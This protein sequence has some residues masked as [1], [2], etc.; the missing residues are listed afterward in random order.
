[1]ARPKTVRAPTTA[2]LPN[3]LRIPSSTPSLT[4]SL[5]KLSRQALL[6]LAFTWLDDRN[7]ASSPPYLQTNDD[8]P[9]DDDALPYPAGKTIEEVRQV[10][11]D[12]QDRK[13]AKR[14]LIERILEGD[15]R[16][17]ITL[18][19]LAMADL[20]YMD[21]HPASLRWT[22]LELSRID[23]KRKNSK[24]LPPADW[25]GSVPRMQAATFVQSLQREISP[26]V[27]AHYHL[28]HSATLPLTFLR[29]FVVDS[30]YQSPRQA[31]EIFTDSSRVIYVAFPDSCPYVYTSIA[32]STGSKSAPSASSVAT[33]TRTLQRL[34]RDS[35]PKALSRPQE[36]FSL[37]ATSLAAKNLPTLL[38]L[39]GSGR[40]TASNGAFSIFADA[41]TEGSP[42]DPRPSNTVSPEEHIRAS[43]SSPTE[44]KENTNGPAT[45]RRSSGIDTAP[46]SPDS[47]KRCL[48]IHSRF[49]TLGSSLAP[50]LLDRLD[51]RLL[52]KPGSSDE[53]YDDDGDDSTFTP[54]ALSLTFSGS[55][56]IGGIRKL[57]ELGIVDPERM[58]SWMTGEEGVSVAT[59]RR[60]KRL[61]KDI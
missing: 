11:G 58:P 28:A 56:V 9:D 52:D 16:H 40:S 38:A 12:L 61:Q 26:L 6:D 53:Q 39:R 21:D 32:V 17:G 60:G 15:W 8:G 42:L 1:M 43:H 13:G 2:S 37:Q 23:T 30:P 5:G 18:R 14:E 20:R 55:D 34:V 7:V 48:A 46:L 3:N 25:S 50:A 45:K 49:G 36:R 19:Q 27:K 31:A 59:V 44:G 10:Y 33:D 57:A 35:I 54:P 4:K 41:A 51:I 47:K 29:I 22:A 24:G